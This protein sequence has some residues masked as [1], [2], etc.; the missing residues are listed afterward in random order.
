MQK[1]W[2]E[3]L[4]HLH[5][6][7]LDVSSVKE[8]VRRWCGEDVLRGVP[9]KEGRHEARADVEESIEEARYYMR[10]LRGIK[11]GEE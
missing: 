2:T 4:G 3:V 11:M 6:R 7:V 5:Y 9:R 10:I 8:C 1:P